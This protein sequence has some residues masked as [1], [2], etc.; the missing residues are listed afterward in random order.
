[1]PDCNSAFLNGE[2]SSEYHFHPGRVAWLQIIFSVIRG[3][4]TLSSK[5]MH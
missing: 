1:M 3:Y 2:I 4:F 5:E